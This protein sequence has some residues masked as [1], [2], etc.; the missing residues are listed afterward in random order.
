MA[1]LGKIDAII[2]RELL[3]EGRKSFTAIAKE[4]N[5]SKD[6]IWKHFKE[7]KK[8]GIIVGATTQYNYPLFGYEGI[9][10]ILI[11]VE[12]HHCNEV[13]KR[14]S[15]KPDIHP[16]RVY[17]SRHNIGVVTTFKNLKDLDDIKEMLIRQNPV[18]ASRTYL[19]TDVRNTPENFSCGIAEDSCL[20]DTKKIVKIGKA[21]RVK[22]D[23][24][25]QQIVEELTKDGRAAFSKIARSMGIST[26]TV[27]KRYNKLV[28]NGFIK[29]VIQF[30]PALMGY[31]ALLNFYIEF[32]SKTEI[33]NAI[34][35][36]SRTPNVSFVVKMSGDYDLN[37]AVFVK[38]IEDSMKMEEEIMKF[39][40]IREIV[41][42]IKKAP[43]KWPGPRQYIS[44][45]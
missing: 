38:D 42:D 43:P 21:G 30:N 3:K 29:V 33:K 18:I 28:R 11:S 2:L 25:D 22:L 9:A 10:S 16:F 35:K 1:S 20:I 8:T 32:L 5:V 37:V 4:N 41:V 31:K 45:F 24:I 23:E 39:P 6:I 19:W 26:D 34:E 40:G 7:M 27:I 36:L 44:T 14:L 17:S 13:F 12:S 15:K